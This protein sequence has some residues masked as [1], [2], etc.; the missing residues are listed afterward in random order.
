[1]HSNHVGGGLPRRQSSRGWLLLPE[2]AITAWEIYM[3]KSGPDDS[4]DG[5]MY[6]A[7]KLVDL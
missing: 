1:M 3:E 2:W 6:P 5:N 4:H 7:G